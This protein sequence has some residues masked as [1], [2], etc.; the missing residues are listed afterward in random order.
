MDEALAFPGASDRTVPRVKLLVEA[1]ILMHYLHQ[2]D[3]AQSYEE[4]AIAISEE[5]KY[6]KGV[7][8]G[9]LLLGRIAMVGRSDQRAARQYFEQSGAVYRTLDD[10]D[11]LAS[12]LLLL[13]LADLFVADYL[14]AR[15][16][17]EESLAVARRAGLRSAYPLGIL[18]MLAYA[19][20]NLSLAKSL[21]EQ[22]L[23]LERERGEVRYDTFT[24]LAKVLT[25]QGELSTAHELLEEA[26]S[27]V[28]TT[29]NEEDVVACE[30]YMIFGNLATAEGNVKR[31]IQLYRMC[32]AGV[33]FFKPIW[34]ECLLY[35][36]GLA[37]SMDQHELVAKLLGAIETVEK[38]L[39][40]LLPIERGDC[41]RLAQAAFDQLGADHFNAAR[42][43]GRS[44]EFVQ[45]AEEAVSILERALRHPGSRDPFT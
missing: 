1:G 41:D 25:R 9:L 11:G 20:G 43:E 15:T 33:R 22:R 37:N 40:P 18:G 5:I 35:I 8:E 16:H 28:R 44:Q 38:T 27:K 3:L 19:E 12:T 30:C 23:V 13:A 6:E 10:H 7:A 26:V 32:L 4:E 21:H 45:A 17:A 2:N 34:G 31:A 29:Q 36:A 42:S 14:Q 39:Q 24:E